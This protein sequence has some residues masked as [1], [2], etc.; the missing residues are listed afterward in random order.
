MVLK[1]LADRR[2]PFTMLGRCRATEKSAKS[3]ILELSDSS[4]KAIELVVANRYTGSHYRRASY[5]SHVGDLAA[6]PASCSE[7]SRPLYF[8]Y[9]ITGANAGLQDL[10]QRLLKAVDRLRAGLFLSW[11]CEPRKRR[12]APVL[13]PYH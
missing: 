3:S 7:S 10:V 8:I 9:K 1:C 2:K 4:N 5:N 13:L 6:I 12:E 11:H